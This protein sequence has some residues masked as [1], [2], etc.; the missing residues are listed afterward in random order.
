MEGVFKLSQDINTAN[1][2]NGCTVAVLL[3]CARAFD[4]VWHNGIRRKL[5]AYYIPP[6][7]T[8]MISSYLK[9]RELIIKE[10]TNYSLK[11]YARAGVPQG[12]IISPSLF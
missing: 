3:D 10:G 4:A 1:K 12:G 9:D 8:R 2:K 7:L 6:K 11:F 5:A